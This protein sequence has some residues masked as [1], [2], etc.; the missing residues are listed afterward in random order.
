MKKTKTVKT[1]V[2]TATW[3]TKVDAL[4]MLIVVIDVVLFCQNY[5]GTVFTSYLFI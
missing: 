4:K 3:T 2:N 1:R 5:P